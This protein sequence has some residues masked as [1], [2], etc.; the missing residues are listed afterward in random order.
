MLIGVIE[1]MPIWIIA[2]LVAELVPTQY[3][4]RNFSKWLLF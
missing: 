1:S 3:I 2:A 4:A